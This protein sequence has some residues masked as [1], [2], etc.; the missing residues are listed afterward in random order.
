M[1]GDGGPW[2]TELQ[3]WSQAL[4]DWRERAQTCELKLDAAVALEVL[5]E[6]L[7]VDSGRFGHR[8]GSLT[9]SALEPMRAIPHKVIVLMGL[10]GA[11]F[12]RPSRRPGF[13]CWSSNAVSVIPAAATRTAMCCS[14]P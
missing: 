8:S 4:D 10:D 12:P 9:V 5:T 13:T 7:S 2:S 11:D 6:A 1:F 14:R 3:S